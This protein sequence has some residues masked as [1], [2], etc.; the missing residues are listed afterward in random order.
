MELKAASMTIEVPPLIS[1]DASMIHRVTSMHKGGLRWIFE[2]VV[3]CISDFLR[4]THAILDFLVSLDASSNFLQLARRF[5]ECHMS[6]L[7]AIQ[8]LLFAT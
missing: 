7:D 3:V 4:T 6:R 2:R 8:D 5:Q 1:F